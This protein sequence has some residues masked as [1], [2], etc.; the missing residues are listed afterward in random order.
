MFNSPLQ[1]WNKFVKRELIYNYDNFF[2][3]KLGYV[4][5]DCV[6]SIKNMINAKRIMLEKAHLYD[7]RINI[8]SSVVKGYSKKECPYIDAPIIFSQKLD[9]ILTQCEGEIYADKI[10]KI[11]LMHLF[12]YYSLVHKANKNLLYS[13]MHD[14]LKN[15]Q[16]PYMTKSILKKIGYYKQIKD[17]RKYNYTFYNIMRFIYR[18]EKR[19]DGKRINILGFNVYR[20]RYADF[21]I[22]RRYLGFIKTSEPDMRATVS[23]IINKVTMNLQDLLLDENGKIKSINK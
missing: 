17:F 7:Y 1:D 14:Y 6:Y 9:E 10:L 18:Y 3:E 11:S 16:N 22:Q 19:I 23:F 12:G 8:S 2:E 13:L 21:K 4:L 5:P 15:T 20:E